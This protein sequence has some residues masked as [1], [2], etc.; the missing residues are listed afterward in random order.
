MNGSS[1]QKKQLTAKKK[2]PG[3][4]GSGRWMICMDFFRHPKDS[5][6]ETR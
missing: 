3:K 5:H 2:K 1:H 4:N 6:I